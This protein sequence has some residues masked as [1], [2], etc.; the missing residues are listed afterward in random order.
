MEPFFT[1]NSYDTPDDTPRFLGDRLSLNTRWYFAGGYIREVCRSRAI[2]LRGLYDRKAWAESSYRVFKLIEGCGGQFHLRGLDNVRSCEPPVVFISNHM[3]TLETMTLPCIIAP[4][5]PVTFVVKESLATHPL[6]GPVMRARAPILVGR[7]NPREDFQ[8]VM[9]EGKALL[10]KGTSIIIFPQ[11]TRSA[12][13]VPEEFNSLGVKLARA[14]G[15]QVVP[16]AVKTDFWGNGKYLKELGAIDRGKP[17]HMVFGQ[18]FA[19]Q[20]TGK[21]E[22]KKVID[23]I[24]SHLRQWGASINQENA[25]E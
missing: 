17:I 12:I 1:G 14:A 4:F 3:S 13:F 9:T 15:V 2:A 24:T 5:L 20:G 8:T 23:F 25:T 6:F 19:T 7:R 18:P 16:V 11:S 10:G 22:Q 21:D